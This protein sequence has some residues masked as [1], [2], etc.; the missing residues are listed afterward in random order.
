MG[1]IKESWDDIWAWERLELK[2]S[3]HF[4]VGRSV[5]DRCGYHRTSPVDTLPW[6]CPRRYGTSQPV[7]AMLTRRLTHINHTRFTVHG[8]PWSPDN[9][10]KITS[11]VGVPEALALDGGHFPAL[12]ISRLASS[13]VRLSLLESHGSPGLNPQCRYVTGPW[14]HECRTLL[15]PHSSSFCQDERPLPCSPA[16]RQFLNFPSPFSH[17]ARQGEKPAV[18][19]AGRQFQTLPYCRNLLWAN[20]DISQYL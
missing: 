5:V 4:K 3:V 13:V 2:K 7:P 12:V 18:A 9:Q 20:I 8:R 16:N 1:V 10:A 15:P 19:I 14:A 11:P 6:L 17:F